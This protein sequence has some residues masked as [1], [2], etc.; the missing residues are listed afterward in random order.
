M[1]EWGNTGVAAGVNRTQ[2]L[3]PFHY[4]PVNCHLQLSTILS[5][6]HKANWFHGGEGIALQTVAT[7]LP[8]FN[9]APQIGISVAHNDDFPHLYLDNSGTIF[10]PSRSLWFG[11]AQA[12][13]PFDPG[14]DAGSG[15]T[16]INYTQR[17]ILWINAWL[18][19]HYRVDPDRIALQG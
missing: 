16:I 1:V 19:K 10:T 7:K 6:G 2:N 5:S 15:D 17:H 9:I 12:F 13:N 14:F 4:D 8:Q 3:V 18:V 11:Y